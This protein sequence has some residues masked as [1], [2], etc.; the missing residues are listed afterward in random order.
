MKRYLKVLALCAAWDHIAN[1]ENII[2]AWK[3]CGFLPFDPNTP[4]QS[5]YIFPDN[6]QVFTPVEEPFQDKPKKVRNQ[7]IL[8]NNEV[9]S[10]DFIKL[11]WDHFSD[12]HPNNPNPPTFFTQTPSQMLLCARF[13][14]LSDGCL[15]SD[16]HLNREP[17]IILT[18]PITN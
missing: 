15:L 4:L 6:H 11:V 7:I 13:S 9:T 2:S 10:K 17:A 3:T 8:G 5:R 14:S 16:I 12:R 18:D 1:F